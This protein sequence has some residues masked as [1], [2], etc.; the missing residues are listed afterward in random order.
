MLKMKLKAVVTIEFEAPDFMTA[1]DRERFIRNALDNL[2]E[3]YKTVDFDVSTRRD[4]APRASRPPS[5][6]AATK[7]AA[8]RRPSASA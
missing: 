7:K 1:G 8:T 5:T 2:G 3:D 4:T 6:K